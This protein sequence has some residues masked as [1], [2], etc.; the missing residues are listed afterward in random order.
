MW[1]RNA[2]SF[3][4]GST[5]RT[6]SCSVSPTIPRVP[7][8]MYAMDDTTSLPMSV[9]VGHAPGPLSIVAVARRGPL[10]PLPLAAAR[11]RFDVMRTPIHTADTR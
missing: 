3:A 8:S 6:T 9:S 4:M 10:E 11:W 5:L 1:K 2:G 7:S